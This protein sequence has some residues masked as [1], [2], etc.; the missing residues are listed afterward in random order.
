MLDRVAV[1]DDKPPDRRAGYDEREIV[2]ACIKHWEVVRHWL[3]DWKGRPSA[4][5]RRLNLANKP[6]DRNRGRPYGEPDVSPRLV[7]F[8]GPYP[9]EDGRET[10]GSWHCLGNGARGDSLVDLVVYLS[11]GCDRRVAGEFLRD[12]VAKIV[13]VPAA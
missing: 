9:F 10:L 2:R 3:A 1:V 13:L 6:I 8:R 7:E 11:G 4:D 5:V 12:L